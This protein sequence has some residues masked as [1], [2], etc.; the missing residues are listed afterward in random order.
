MFMGSSVLMAQNVLP[1]GATPL[2]LT[3]HNRT[4]GYAEHTIHFDV[5][6][7]VEYTYSIDAD[8]A[9][10]LNSSNGFYVHV[11]MINCESIFK[12]ILF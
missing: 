5:T 1:E 3:G 11:P 2:L 4:V 10:V 6:A 7:N 12:S 9:T 8:W